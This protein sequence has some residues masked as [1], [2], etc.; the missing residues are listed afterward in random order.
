VSKIFIIPKDEKLLGSWIP[1]SALE[2]NWH[3]A[4]SYTILS[5][6]SGLACRLGLQMSS[7]CQFYR[8]WFYV[9]PFYPFILYF[10]LWLLPYIRFP[11]CLPMVASMYSIVCLINL[12][13][14]SSLS[15]V[16]LPGPIF[17]LR[18]FLCLWHRR[19]SRR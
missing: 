17:F 8:V 4:S 10:F 6:R 15:T 9:H 18:S 2:L 1:K 12:G 14:P 13:I 3:F 5:S 7:I 11:A 16:I 19:N